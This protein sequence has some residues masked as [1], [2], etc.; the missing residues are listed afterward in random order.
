MNEYTDYEILEEQDRSGPGYPGDSFL[1]ELDPDLAFDD[2]DQG[3]GLPW[4]PLV[5][6]LVLVVVG[7]FMGRLLWPDGAPTAETEGP[8]TPRFSEGQVR[9]AP[10]SEMEL[11]VSVKPLSK[12]PTL[13]SSDQLVR[14]IVSNLSSHPQVLTWLTSE[15]L[16]RDFVVVV[17][18]VAFDENPAIHVPFLRPNR[19]FSVDRSSADR[20]TASEASFARFDLLADVFSSLDA[21]GSA[22]AVLQLEPLMNDSWSELGYPGTFRQGLAAAVDR[23]RQVPAEAG[24]LEVREK[25]LS[26]ELVEPSLERLSPAQKQLLRMGPRNIAL[27][28]AKLSEIAAELRL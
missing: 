2:D 10:L 5:V 19:T 15:D 3:S 23:L 16:V 22:A 13:G 9:P 24:P 1:D 26:W 12:L 14:S 17:G 11:P 21:R 28:Q 27:I 20:G 25:V 7:V 6:A 4:I 18:N 8:T